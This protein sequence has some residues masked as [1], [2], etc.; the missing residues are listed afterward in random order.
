MFES[1]EIMKRLKY[2]SSDSSYDSS[3][4]FLEFD[5]NEKEEY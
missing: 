5:E 4:S 1:I 3:S 2:Y